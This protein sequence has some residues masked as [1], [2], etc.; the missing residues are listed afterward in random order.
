VSYRAIF[1]VPSV[2]DSIRH[3]VSRAKRKETGGSLV[4][5]LSA[6]NAV[7]VTHASGP[8]PRAELAYDSVLVD[9]T[10][11][12]EF[13]NR[14]FAQSG[15]RLDYIGDWHRH[16]CWSLASSRRD[17]DAM[18]DVAESRCCSIS[19][20]ISIIYRHFPEKLVAYAFLENRL[21]PVRKLIIGAVHNFR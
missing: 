1:V 15:G 12:S 4:G 6:D 19:H 14:I 7:V 2:L 13:T 5:Y 11:S 3:E 21:L 10:F 20:P 18:R 9:G 16:P 17:V 8:G